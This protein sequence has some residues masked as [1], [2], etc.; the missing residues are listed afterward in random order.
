M[1]AI[2]AFI[3]TLGELGI[4][5]GSALLQSHNTLYTALVYGSPFYLVMN[6][7]NADSAFLDKNPLY[8]GLLAFHIIKYF[9]I[10]R[11]QMGDDYIALRRGAILMEA[12]YLGLSAYY[13]N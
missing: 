5:I 4:V 3:I 9:I 8:M 12:A 2:L 6:L 11:A 1:S 7:L 13:M 10:F